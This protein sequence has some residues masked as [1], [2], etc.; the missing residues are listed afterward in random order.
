MRKPVSGHPQIAQ[1]KQR[2]QLRRVFGKTPVAHFG[3]TGQALDHPKAMP[4]LGAHA[5]FDLPGRSSK[6]PQ[7]DFLSS[8]RRLPGAQRDAPLIALLGPVHLR[9][10]LAGAVLDG[11]GGCDEGGVHNRSGLEQRSR[12]RQ[13]GVNAVQDLAPAG[14]S[15]R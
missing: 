1:C 8:A 10:T 3:E 5:R 7:G 2:E 9:V 4:H 15:R 6:A 14:W 11:N 12:V 13:L